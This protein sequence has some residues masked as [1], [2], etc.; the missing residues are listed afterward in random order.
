MLDNDGD[1][2]ARR[3][4]RRER[5]KPGVGGA[6]AGLGSPRLAADEVPRDIR[7]F[8]MTVDDHTAEHF[9]QLPRR[10]LGE[11]APHFFWFDCLS[12]ALTIDSPVSYTHL[13]LPTSALV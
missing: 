8:A 4:G 1:S 10:V 9:P 6:V 12:L 2:D 11:N 3:L 7:P 13:T 5:D